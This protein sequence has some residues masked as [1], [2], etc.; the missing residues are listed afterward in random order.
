MWCRYGTATGRAGSGT[1]EEFQRAKARYD[2]DPSSVKLMIYFKDAP[3]P[4]SELDPVQLA[5][6]NEFRQSLGD[7]GL[8][9]WK[10]TNQ[11]QFEKFVRVHLAKQIQAWKSRDDQSGNNVAESNSLERGVQAS[12]DDGDDLGILDLMEV[13]EDRFEQITAIAERI[14]AATEEI[15][16]RIGERTLQMNGLSRDS[17]GIVNRKAAKHLIAMAASDMDNYTTRMEAEIP[18]FSNSLNDGM[19]ALIRASTMSIDLASQN[20]PEQ[21]KQGLGAIETLLES[22]A[23]SKQSTTRFRDTIAGL[24]RMTSE[25]NKSKRG[26]VSV[27]D[28]MINE[29]GNG[30]SLLREASAVVRGLLD[31]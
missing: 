13:F 22:L 27:L 18:I 16:N 23:L 25:L 6:V 20:D 31:Q 12:D 29:L 2:T 5:K 10:F 28:K 15:G 24:P 8:L 4:P 14:S 9:Y 11:E 26:V 30:Q 1:V 3:I 17:Q 19:N 7:E 21:A